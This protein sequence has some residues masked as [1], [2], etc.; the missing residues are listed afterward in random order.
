MYYYD[1][2]P[3]SVVGVAR[4][5]KTTGRRRNMALCR[6]DPLPHTDSVLAP[7][8]TYTARALTHSCRK[9]ICSTFAPSQMEGMCKGT[10]PPDQHVI[11]V[12]GNSGESKAA[13]F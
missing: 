12:W 6:R 1:S 9:T 13:V 11:S 8:N 10:Q 4:C 7:P 2:I 3:Q 5:G